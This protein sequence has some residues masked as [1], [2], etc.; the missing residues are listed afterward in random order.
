[1][2]CSIYHEPSLLCPPYFSFWKCVKEKRSFDEHSALSLPSLQGDKRKTRKTRSI[3]SPENRT[4]LGSQARRLAYCLNWLLPQHPSEASR[5]L[6]WS[7]QGFWLYRAFHHG[8]VSKHPGNLGMQGSVRQKD[9]LLSSGK[10]LSLT[11]VHLQ[12]E[13]I[14]CYSHEHRLY[15]HGWNQQEQL[16]VWLRLREWSC[17]NISPL[18]V[19]RSPSAFKFNIQFWNIFIFQSL[20]G[21][22]PG[23]LVIERWMGNLHEENIKGKSY[24]NNPSLK[25]TPY[26]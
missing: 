11:H 19:S 24:R 13:G 9:D 1:M 5:E 10:Q 8:P 22:Q 16:K 25:K 14:G 23:I 4:G 18:N 17:I 6:M 15:R 7:C 3:F 20:L 2:S 21:C 26:I 12:Q